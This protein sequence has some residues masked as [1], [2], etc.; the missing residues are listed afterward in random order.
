MTRIE[1]G[2]DETRRLGGDMIVFLLLVILYKKGMLST[3]LST[4]HRP[5]LQ[6]P[7]SSNT[8]FSNLPSILPLY[9]PPCSITSRMLNSNN[10]HHPILSNVPR[11]LPSSY[12]LALSALTVSPTAFPSKLHSSE[13]PSPDPPPHPQRHTGLGRTM[14][15]RLNLHRCI[16]H[17]RGIRGRP[18]PCRAPW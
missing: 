17:P 10:L 11:P 15:R 7:L 4:A 6:L 1:G 2:N 8:R 3:W 18:T 14:E 9:I 13:T 5:C 12:S 16:Y